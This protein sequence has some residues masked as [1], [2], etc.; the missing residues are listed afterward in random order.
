MEG[1]KMKNEK[2]IEEFKQNGYTTEEI[3]EMSD[4][5]FVY[6]AVC[7]VDGMNKSDINKSL[8]KV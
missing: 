4:D 2:D 7:L 5:E 8:G 1:R 6:T 3:A